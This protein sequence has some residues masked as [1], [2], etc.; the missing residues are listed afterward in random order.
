MGC[1]LKYNLTK[2]VLDKS[3]FLS[4]NIY[5]TGKNKMNLTVMNERVLIKP[6]VN[7]AKT[8]GGILFTH[9]GEE[10]TNEGIVVGVGE[11]LTT[12]E[13]IIVPID[14]AIGDRIVY[15]VNAGIEVKLEGQ[16]YLMLKEQDIFAVLVKEG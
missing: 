4:Y 8:A 13:N 2:P 5:I 15:D 1:L 10:K 12:S 14:V 6:V 16:T 7:E 9:T 3:K 11:G